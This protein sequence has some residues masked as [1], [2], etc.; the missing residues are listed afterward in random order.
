MQGYGGFVRSIGSFH[1]MTTQV[2]AHKANEKASLEEA[3]QIELAGR[4]ERGQ[5]LDQS[6][7]ILAHNAAVYGKNGV[8]M[9]GTPM[10]VQIEAARRGRQDVQAS[11]RT[12]AWKTD[13]ALSEARMQKYYSKQAV[14][15]GVLNIFSDILG[16][17][18][19]AYA[20]EQG[21]S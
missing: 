3:R 1:D 14:A 12:T 18:S 19:K 7:Q 5:L 9:E 15:S 16:G 6:R 10:L 4:Y 13:S 11:G 2:K 21:A 20:A 8:S 17:A